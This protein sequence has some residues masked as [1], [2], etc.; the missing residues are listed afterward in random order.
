[1]NYINGEIIVAISDFVQFFFLRQ[2]RDVSDNLN[3]RYLEKMSG[4]M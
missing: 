3:N 4:L 2:A 1:M